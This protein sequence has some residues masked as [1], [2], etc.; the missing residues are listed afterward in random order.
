MGAAASLPFLTQVSLPHHS[1]TT[2]AAVA[3]PTGG[4]GQYQ[5]GGGQVDG[6]AGNNGAAGAAAG[7]AGESQ[8][9]Q[10]TGRSAWAGWHDGGG[11][12]DKASLGI[13]MIRSQ[14]GLGF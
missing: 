11:N 12:R 6:G 7:S 2:A 1:V 9:A 8:G 13:L 10:T 3:A 4:G 5:W 14:G